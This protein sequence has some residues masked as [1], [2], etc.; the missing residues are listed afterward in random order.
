M[1]P[2]DLLTKNPT[3]TVAS[4]E[5]NLAQ[6][7]N[8]HLTRNNKKINLWRQKVIVWNRWAA[9]GA[10][11]WGYEKPEPPEDLVYVDSRLYRDLWDE[12]QNMDNVGAAFITYSYTPTPADPVPV[13]PRRPGQPSPPP[14]DKTGWDNPFG[15]PSVVAPTPAP[16]PAPAQPAGQTPVDIMI[17]AI[18][19]KFAKGDLTFEQM[20]TLLGQVAALKK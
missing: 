12:T 9:N 4:R 11:P 5:Q 10:I 17:A 19:Q 2:G 18:A 16:A 6:A 7:V 20:Q 8:D 13:E 14:V 1:N 15:P 3:S